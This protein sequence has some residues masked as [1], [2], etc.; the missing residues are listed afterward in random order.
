MTRCCDR[1]FS[2]LLVASSSRSSFGRATWESRKRGVRYPWVVCRIGS[3]TLTGKSR[4]T[5]SSHNEEYAQGLE[6]NPHYAEIPAW[7]SAPDELSDATLRMLVLERVLVYNNTAKGNAHY[8][9]TACLC[10]ASEILKS[11]WPA[12]LLSR[13]LQ[14]VPRRHKSR[15]IPIVRLSGKWLG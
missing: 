14:N 9:R 11:D 13:A 6:T 4:P 10:L 3:W 2:V 8:A 7:S 12:T 1:E 15:C 5:L